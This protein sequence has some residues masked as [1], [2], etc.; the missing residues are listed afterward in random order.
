[1]KEGDVLF[2]IDPEDYETGAG[3]GEIGAL[4]LW[5]EQIEVGRSQDEQLK[6]GVK[7]AEAGVKRMRS[8]SIGDTLHRLEPLLP[9]HFAPRNKSTR[10]ERILSDRDWP[11]GTK[12]EHRARASSQLQ[13]LLAQRPGAVAAI[14]LAEL[15]LSY[16][17]VIAPFPDVSSISTFR[18][19][20]MLPPG[21]PSSR[22]STRANGT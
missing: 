13:T 19:A 9:K 8:S 4:P 20:P 2:E 7:A 1:M 15:H 11:R 22:C 5:I 6:F 17:K 16:C 10:R 12:T 14:K 3:K 21:F 18:P